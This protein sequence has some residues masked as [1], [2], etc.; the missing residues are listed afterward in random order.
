MEVAMVDGDVCQRL[1]LQYLEVLL[2]F[3]LSS[4]KSVQKFV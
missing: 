2:H 1:D 3:E 4:L